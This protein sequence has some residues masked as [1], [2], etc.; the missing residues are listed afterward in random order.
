MAET[1]TLSRFTIETK[2]EDFTLHIEDD[3]GEVIAFDA[4]AEQID[5]IVEA[6]D[7]ILDEDDS[8]DEIED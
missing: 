4:T 2:G 6:L 8:L 7:D 1:K 3:A 5:L